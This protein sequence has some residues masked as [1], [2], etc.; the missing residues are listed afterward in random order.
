MSRKTMNPLRGQ[1]TTMRTQL[2]FAVLAPAFAVGLWANFRS[3][4]YTSA[5]NTGVISGVVSSSNGPEAGVWVIA[6]TD[7]LATKFRKIVVTDDAG[8][9]LLPELPQGSFHVW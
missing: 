3:P 2:V 7:D 9:F 1:A 4:V 6:E 8:R 5:T